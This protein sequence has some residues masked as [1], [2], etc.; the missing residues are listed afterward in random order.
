MQLD[1]EVK[2]KFDRLSNICVATIAFRLMGVMSFLIIKSSSNDI[3][4]SRSVKN[5]VKTSSNRSESG[6]CN[7]HL[8]FRII[9]AGNKSSE[10]V[11]SQNRQKNDAIVC[12]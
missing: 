10:G 11:S 5:E 4:K 2:D 8:S 12:K 7:V 6:F 3:E 1:Q 9:K